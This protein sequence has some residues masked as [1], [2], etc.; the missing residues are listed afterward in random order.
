MNYSSLSPR[1][2]GLFLGVVVALAL[3]V[4]VVAVPTEAWACGGC[5]GC[6]DRAYD[7]KYDM[8]CGSAGAVWCQVCSYCY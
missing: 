6:V 2:R 5:G 4:A 8:P 1:F 7:P 3:V